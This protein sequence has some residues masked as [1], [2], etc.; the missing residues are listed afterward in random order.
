MACNI[1]KIN[2][3]KNK[4][5][6]QGILA[7]SI[8]F[9]GI[10]AVTSCGA[11]QKPGKDQNTEDP[12]NK[13]NQVRVMTPAELAE[14]QEVSRLSKLYNPW[15]LPPKPLEQDDLGVWRKSDVAFL[16]PGYETLK[17]RMMLLENATR[18]VR[19]QT[20][21]ISGDE[22]GQAFANKLVELAGRGLDV[23]LIVD[24]TSGLF[25]GWQ[26]LYFFLTSHG[27]KVN[28]YLP[29]WMQIGNNPNVFVNMFFGNTLKERF[30]DALTTT[31]IENHR[32]HEKIMV[33]DAE[34]PS[35]A[36][37]LVGGTNIANEYYDILSKPGDLK[38]RDQDML[39]RGDIVTDLALAFDSN[40]I[41]INAVNNQASFSGAIE[42]FV[43]RQR[44]SFG[45]DKATGITLRPY[46]SKQYEEAL[47]SQANLRWHTANIRQIHHRPL[48]NEFTAE[49]RLTKAITD[50]QR[51]VII[52]NPYIIPSEAM[53]TAMI[54]AA[55][56]GIN[57]KILTNSLASGDTPTV[58]EVGRTYYKRLIL[59]TQ[60][61]NRWP[62]SVPVSIYEWGGDAVFKNGF[63]NFHAKYVVID[64][65]LAFLGSFN[66]D[67]RSATWNSEVLYETDAQLL[68]AQLLE[69]QAAD[70]GPGFATLV[71]KEMAAS[72]KTTK[73]T[74][75][76]LR[77]NA[78]ILF[79]DFL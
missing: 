19:V 8:L 57:I 59:E 13:I 66:L 78:L 74:Y 18:S 76:T 35:H 40:V 55:R 4:E 12:K 56:R 54:N 69:Q 23:Q 24:D 34:V 48:H 75:E 49:K 9:S 2:T 3:N 79:K 72:Y 71:T 17:S 46:P 1:K 73:T 27:V 43:S 63:S 60:P 65:Q 70:S 62:Y 68:V 22:T 32:F 45:Q 26:N 67:P 29:V 20:F 41:D 42:D 38:W 5:A 37:A 28:G 44:G 6:K 25:D 36:M 77:R 51:E 50:A 30:G 52:V 16:R 14:A 11:F 61:S 58:Q 7:A 33:I 53:M 15:Q 64:R 10:F 31:K 39:L 21:L 47:T